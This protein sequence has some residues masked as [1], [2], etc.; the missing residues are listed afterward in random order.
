[1]EGLLQKKKKKKAFQ[2]INNLR[3]SFCHCLWYQ[4]MNTQENN[5]VIK[6]DLIK[7]EKQAKV[8]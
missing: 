1:M 2:N 5:V 6:T 3:L 7:P 4:V 8:S